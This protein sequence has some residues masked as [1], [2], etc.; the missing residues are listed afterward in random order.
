M[1]KEHK[2]RGRREDQ[3]KRKRDHDDE[4][5]SKRFRKDDIEHVQAENPL[6]HVANDAPR[7]DAAPFYGMLDE[8]EQEYFKKADEMLELNQFE[9]PEDRRIFLA[10]VWKE[11]EGKELKMATSQTSRLLERLILL[12]SEDQLKSLFQKFSGHFLNLVQNRF[13][14][15][16]CETLFIQAAPA[17]S[18]EN[19]SVKTE[20]LNTPP[21]SDPDEIIVSME[22]LFLY[23]LGELEGNIGFL[24]TEKYA[25]HVLRVLLVILS[26]EPLEKQGKSVTQSKKKEK[27]TISGA[28]DERILEKRVVPESFLEALEKVISDSVSGIEAH[29]LRSLAIHPLGGPT[30]QLLLKLELSHF[31][32]SRAKD[33]KS[34]IHRLLPDNPIA[35]GTES[36]IL[37]NGLVYDSVGSHLLE[38]IIEHAP[39]K[40]FKQIYG[41]FFKERMGSLAR[42]EIAGYVVGKILERLGKDDLE[43]AMRQIVDQIPSLVE[44]NRTAPIKTLIERCV[45]REVDCSPIKAQ[46]E[47]AYAGPHGFE[48][49]RI[50]KL[51]EDDGKP[52][53][54]HGESN[55]KVHGSLLAQTMMTVD[56]PLGQLVFDSLANLSPELSIQLARDGTASRTLQ[57]ALVS[58]NATVIF[59][60]KMIQQFYGKIGELA[61]DPKASHVVDAIWY[62]T[63]GLAFIRE[64]IA[65]ELAEN[66]NSLRESQVGRK[67]WKNWQMDLYKR[68]RNDWVAQARTTAG[69]EVF[70]SFPD[71][72]QSDVAAPARTHRASRHM[73]AIELA[74][75]KFAAAKAAQAKD[76]KKPKKGN[77]PTNGS[78]ETPRSLVAQ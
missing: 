58:R 26:G 55:E 47:T 68:R 27:V 75:Q 63:V 50:L 6:Q 57:A 21:A 9:S 53:A 45:A 49:T 76:G 3:K 14:S 18:Q 37:I 16:C 41:E 59:R 62:G 29:Y 42:N 2:K 46:L 51:N 12:A 65:E 30:L 15:H 28:G 36:A 64:R 43:E 1:P 67:V 23:T 25:S 17:V 40:L 44:R 39:G 11:A 13:A 20:A 60:R 10:S 32:K 8:Q 69:N 72:S 52:R 22:N 34:I 4:S 7:Q 33:E 38:T 78:G 31:G 54:R 70:Q 24:M 71:E 48:V 35:E 5:A 56:G 73:S 61:L 74:R 66:E 77:N 19:A